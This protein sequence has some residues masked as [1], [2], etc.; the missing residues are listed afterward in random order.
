MKSLY[1]AGNSLVH[2]IAAPPKLAGLALFAAALFVTRR[3]EIL[4]GLLIAACAVL[5]SLRIRPAAALA[6]LRPLLIAILLLGL[7]TLIFNGPE[8]A[9]VAVLR[10]TALLFAG[11]AVTLSTPIA[12]FVEAITRA[13]WPLE[14]LGL[15]RAADLGLAVGLVIR[16]VPDILARHRALREAHLARGLKPRLSTLLGPLIVLTLRDA[17]NIAAAIDARGIRGPRR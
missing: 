14:R 5:A 15:V 6:A 17:D 10:L 9:G 8:Q 7:L 16:F 4:I 1:V 13:A 3:P 12:D 11:S 2:R